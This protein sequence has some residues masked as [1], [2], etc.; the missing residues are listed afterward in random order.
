M[1]ELNELMK[2]SLDVKKICCRCK[3]TI[4]ERKKKKIRRLGGKDK[5]KQSEGKK[6]KKR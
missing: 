6:K 4:R 5:V 1:K 2:R 3:R